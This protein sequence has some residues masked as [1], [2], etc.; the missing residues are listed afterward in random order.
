MDRKLEARIARLE[1]LVYHKIKNENMELDNLAKRIDS[2]L[3]QYQRSTHDLSAYDVKAYSNDVDVM[4]YGDYD[5]GDF[6]IR[7]NKDGGYEVEDEYYV[8]KFDTIQQVV[9]YL[10]QKDHDIV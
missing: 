8:E 10:I 7:I 1:K 4:F 2:L 3:N 5:Y 6:T 9:D